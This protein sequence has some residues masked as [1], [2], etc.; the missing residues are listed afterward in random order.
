MATSTA[1]HIATC[2][3]LPRTLKA[4]MAAYKEETGIPESAI[5]RKA[6]LKYLAEHAPE[7]EEKKE[8]IAA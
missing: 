8:E 5:I 7:T 6:V 1:T 2:I 3:T 4:R